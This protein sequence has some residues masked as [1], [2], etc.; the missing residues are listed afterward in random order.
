MDCE[1]VFMLE[2][3]NNER[4]GS[5]KNSEIINITHLLTLE[6]KDNKL[7]TH[8]VKIKPYKK[9]G[10]MIK[11]HLEAYAKLRHVDDKRNYINKIKNDLLTMAPDF[12]NYNDSDYYVDIKEPYQTISEIGFNQLYTKE[13]GV[14]TES[15]MHLYRAFKLK[16]HYQI[17]NISQSVIAYSYRYKG[18]RESTYDIDDIFS[19]KVCTNFGYGRSSYFNMTLYYR[20]LPII[21]YQNIVQYAFF[22]EKEI[23][24]FTENYEV[25]ESSWE[26]CFN[27]VANF[28]NDYYRYNH[29]DIKLMIKNNVNEF[30]AL[31]KSMMTNDQINYYKKRHAKFNRH[32][33]N[34]YLSIA[35][36]KFIEKDWDDEIIE[37]TVDGDRDIMYESKIYIDRAKIA[38][39]ALNNL[40]NF[41][42]MSD[43]I[44]L[45]E[46]TNMI[47]K[48]SID[49]LEKLKRYVISNQSNDDDNEGRPS[50]LFEDHERIKMY[51]DSLNKKIHEIK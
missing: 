28:I 51:I 34:D 30:M 31:F 24:N 10:P 37:D 42:L 44:D 48:L 8:K 15:I 27:H 5:C 1:D 9:M 16:K 23:L 32:K 17:L 13:F 2:L 6:W 35:N 14:V 33:I 40:N 41:K 38:L 7:Y 22:D 3:I 18:W 12:F 19:I 26:D 11:S 50:E 20:N 36:N 29:H 39:Y 43:L 4:V 25:I 46:V 45:E 49:F 21:P 47:K